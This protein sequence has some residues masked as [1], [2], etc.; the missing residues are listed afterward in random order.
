MEHS[1]IKFG[2]DLI[3]SGENSVPVLCV[4]MCV[5]VFENMVLKF[6]VL[7]NTCKTSSWAP[8]ELSSNNTLHHEIRY[9]RNWSLCTSRIFSRSNLHRS[10]LYS[11]CKVN[12]LFMFNYLEI[13]KT[14]EVYIYIYHATRVSC[15]CT[16]FMRD[17]LCFDRYLE[18][19]AQVTLYVHVMYPLSLSGFNRNRNF[20]TTSSKSLLYQTS[21]IRVY[22][23]IPN[24]LGADRRIRRYN[25]PI[26]R[27]F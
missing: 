1:K 3:L 24:G 20:P 4:C 16:T 12:T 19:Y 26:I 5:C 14:Y 8:D 11:H 10:P 22:I 2:L 9:F 17:T 13:R 6:T 18:R 25:F 21:K 23:Y 7:W 27:Y 15:L